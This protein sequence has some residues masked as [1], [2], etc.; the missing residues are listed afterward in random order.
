MVPS[1]G[2][3]EITT[4][5]ILSTLVPVP[6]CVCFSRKT[7]HDKEQQGKQGSPLRIGGL[8]LLSF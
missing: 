6:T 3:H 8:T 2:G 5:P 1:N 4:R 7:G